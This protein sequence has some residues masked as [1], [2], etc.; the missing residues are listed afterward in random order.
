MNIIVGH[1]PPVDRHAI[2]MSLLKQI[3]K[4]RVRD[5]IIYVRA[6]GKRLYF[7]IIRDNCIESMSLGCNYI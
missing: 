1:I 5:L 3:L 2:H 7:V 4:V 6:L